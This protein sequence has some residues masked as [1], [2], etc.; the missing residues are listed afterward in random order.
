MIGVRMLS[1]TATN[2]FKLITKASASG[3]QY[4]QVDGKGENKEWKELNKHCD[5]L[6]YGIV[7]VCY[8][9]R[10]QFL[11]RIQDDEEIETAR[12]PSS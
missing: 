5:G 4:Y 2:E 1:T 8:K 9:L 10:V 6:G 12:V 11:R 7:L 3:L